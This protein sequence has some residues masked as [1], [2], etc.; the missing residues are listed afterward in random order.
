MQSSLPNEAF[1]FHE[2]EEGIRAIY[3]VEK[4]FQEN[5]EP[6]LGTEKFC[7]WRLLFWVDF[8]EISFFS[9]RDV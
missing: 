6:T 8:W 5:P 3:C 9:S 1:S 7:A 4:D 2:K